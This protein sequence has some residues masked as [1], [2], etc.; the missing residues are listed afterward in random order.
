MS[1]EKIARLET[2]A[3]DH[4][5][6]IGSLETGHAV[7]DERHKRHDKRISNLEINW[8]WII[9][10]VAAILIGGAITASLKGGVF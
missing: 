4:T 7:N 8:S 6:R 2:L 10:T 9:K 5:K 1:D 3:D